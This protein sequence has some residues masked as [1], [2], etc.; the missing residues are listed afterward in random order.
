MTVA[1]WWTATRRTQLA[2]VV[3]A[4]ATRTIRQRGMVMVLILALIPIGLMTVRAVFLP[5][6]LRIDVG[7]ASGDI[8]RLFTGFHLR[9]VVL[10]SCALAMIR[11]I[12]SEVSE[13]T[14]HL[15]FLAPLRREILT[16]GKFIGTL[17]TL[18]LVL[19]TS[20]LAAWFIRYAGCGLDFGLAFAFSLRGISQLAGH[21]AAITVATITYSA[22]FF[23]VGIAF[24][25]SLLV[26][27]GYVGFELVAPFVP[28]SI[29][30]L[31]AAQLAG[32]WSPSPGGQALAALSRPAFGEITSLV[33]AAVLVIGA[34]G[35]AVAVVRRM[36]VA[37]GPDEE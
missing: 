22:L 12:R 28:D 24:R 33:G 15:S 26:I 17:F 14:L 37:Y 25:R 20:T 11:P 4:E 30:W 32:A 31:S 2:A 19:W 27:V 8:A 7:R 34:M 16:V 29:R 10:F 1:S 21:L 9:V 6:A 13:Q 3:R 35:L 18:L 5:D 23:A 36:Q